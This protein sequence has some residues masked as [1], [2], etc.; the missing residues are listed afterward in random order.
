MLT[1]LRFV[2]FFDDSSN[3]SIPSI[4][5]DYCQITQVDAR[6]SYDTLIKFLHP[7]PTSPTFLEF[8]FPRL[9]LELAA[10]LVTCRPIIGV[11]T[12][13]RVSTHTNQPRLI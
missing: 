1:F 12:S 8:S 11:F 7:S 2:Y 13:H 6:W 5:T 3:K 4:E 10:L 9:E